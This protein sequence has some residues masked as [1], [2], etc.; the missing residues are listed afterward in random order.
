MELT[1]TIFNIRY[2]GESCDARYEKHNCIGVPSH[3]K[4]V[5]DDGNCFFRAVSY[6]ISGTE[7]NHT[8]LRNATVEHLLQTKDIFCNTL[9]KEFRTVREY[10]LGKRIMEDS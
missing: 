6:V 7:S 1:K 9:R 5:E 4:I 2:V 3:I 10:V 8:I